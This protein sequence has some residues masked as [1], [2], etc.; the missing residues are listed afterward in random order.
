MDPLYRLLHK[1]LPEKLAL[2]W[3]PRQVDHNKQD[4]PAVQ[5][6]E[7]P[8]LPSRAQ[9]PLGS[10]EMRT[11]LAAEILQH[12][13]IWN[14]QHPEYKS[15]MKRT[16]TFQD[17]ASRLGVD[18]KIIRREWGWVLSMARKSREDNDGKVDEKMIARD[19]LQK[20]LNV[21][22]LERLGSLPKGRYQKRNE[23]QKPKK[24]RAAR[25]N[26]NICEICNE[27]IHR[28][29]LEGHMNKHNG[30]QPYA[31]SHEGC[32]KR[33][34]SKPYL[35]Q[36]ETSV[37]EEHRVECT[38]C[39]QRCPSKH[40]LEIHVATKHKSHELPCTICGKLL[41]HRSAL[42]VHM[43][44]HRTK[45]PCK[46]C[47]AA[48]TTKWGLAEHMRIHTKEKPFECE[49]CGER[50]RTMNARKLHAFKV[51]YAPVKT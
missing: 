12:E 47:D 18:W 43:S 17:I 41:K 11:K 42:L 1:T 38:E 27:T 13:V 5:K 33:F 20:L 48:L 46:V 39:G 34:T 3:P 51:H 19:P 35:K 16:V 50:F 29:L 32:D 14:E 8:E 28:S 23:K 25:A 7:V 36:H 2:R 26:Y 44:R 24:T 31:C 4:K 6:Y 37:H 22:L 15:C 9:R 21:T 40:K 30:L 45:Y 10:I 49:T